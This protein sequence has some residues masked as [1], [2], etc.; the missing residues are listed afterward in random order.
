M[1]SVSMSYVIV[2]FV[3]ALKQTFWIM[4]SLGLPPILPVVASYSQHYTK[5]GLVKFSSV[6]TRTIP[7][8][9]NSTLYTVGRIGLPG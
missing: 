8:I 5:S 2:N 7:G 3:E 9:R 6:N 4:R 1:S